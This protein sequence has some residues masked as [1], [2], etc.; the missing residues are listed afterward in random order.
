[1]AKAEKTAP[2][3][4]KDAAP[5]KSGM[6]GWLVMAA[7]G[8]ISGATGFAVPMVFLNASKSSEAKGSH[9]AEPAENHDKGDHDSAKHES[10][11]PSSSKRDAN[12][13][14]FVPFGEVVVNLAE[15]KLTRYLRVTLTLQVDAAH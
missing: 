3:A 7:V 14:S 8:L 5:A 11:K 6:M 4:T 15:E 10:S 12:Q 1:M 13:P 9:S 2:D